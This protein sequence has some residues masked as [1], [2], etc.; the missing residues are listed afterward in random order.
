MILVAV[1]GCLY[2]LCI[3][4]VLFPHFLL[5]HHGLWI[6]IYNENCDFALLFCDLVK[7]R[8]H[9][10]D[11]NDDHDHIMMIMERLFMMIVMMTRADSD[12][13]L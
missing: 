2:L 10:H 3:N 4:T 7:N 11:H 6:I 1:V 5:L 9:D 12:D 8:H 13:C